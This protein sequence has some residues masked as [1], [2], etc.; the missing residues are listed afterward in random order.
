MYYRTIVQYIHNRIL[1]YNNRVK[2]TP[3]WAESCVMQISMDT[4]T[5]SPRNS[6]ASYLSW[7]LRVRENIWSVVQRVP[8]CITIVFMIGTKR[9]LYVGLSCK[10]KVKKFVIT[11]LLSVEEI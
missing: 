11:S 10:G 6:H 8:V 3:I 4:E 2:Y 5:S 9:Q 7:S 1:L